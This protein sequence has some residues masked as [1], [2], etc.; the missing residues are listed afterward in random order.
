MPE[1]DMSPRGLGYN[2]DTWDEYYDANGWPEYCEC[3]GQHV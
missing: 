3:C 1:V 2:Y